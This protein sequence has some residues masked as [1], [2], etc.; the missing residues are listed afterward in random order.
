M[1]KYSFTI[2]V[3]G[4]QYLFSAIENGEQKYF[5]RHANLMSAKLRANELAKKT[6]EWTGGPKDGWKSI[7]SPL[8]AYKHAILTAVEDAIDAGVAGSDIDTMLLR[9]LGDI[10]VMEQAKCL[11]MITIEEAKALGMKSEKY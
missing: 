2:E 6:V 4:D 11:G 1:I 7:D 5:S 3:F 9:V 10:A 8:D